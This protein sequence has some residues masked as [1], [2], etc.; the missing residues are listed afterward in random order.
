MDEYKRKPDQHSLP[1]RWIPSLLGVLFVVSGATK[2]LG[3]PFQVEM[4]GRFQLPA[5]WALYAIG[6]AELL[7]GALLILGRRK[8]LAG[9][10]LSTIML[11]AIVTHLRI[12]EYGLALVPLACLVLLAVS[13]DSGAGE[14]S[15]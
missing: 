10:L 6:A 13:R 3:A 4:F 5:W 9:G 7:G 8:R 11:G 14:P 1:V 15:R 12:G 2:L